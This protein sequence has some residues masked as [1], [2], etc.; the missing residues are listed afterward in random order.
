M[1]KNNIIITMTYFTVDVMN[2]SIYLL[3]II[4]LILGTVV[5]RSTGIRFI[6]YSG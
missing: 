3:V 2:I 1:S 5:H 6:V 4:N